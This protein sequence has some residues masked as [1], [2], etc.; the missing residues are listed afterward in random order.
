MSTLPSLHSPTTDS[1]SNTRRVD[2]PANFHSLARSCL[3]LFW[4]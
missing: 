2:G 4:F 3:Q 1:K